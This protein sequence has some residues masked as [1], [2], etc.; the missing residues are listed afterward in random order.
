MSINRAN[1]KVGNLAQLTQFF[2]FLSIN[3]VSRVLATVLLSEPF[4][5]S[6]R[7]GDLLITVAACK[8]ESLL[9][10]ALPAQIKGRRCASSEVDRAI[11]ERFTSRRLLRATISRG[12]SCVHYQRLHPYARVIRYRIGAVERA[13]NLPELHVQIVSLGI[14]Q[15]DD[16]I[17]KKRSW[18][19]RFWAGLILSLAIIIFNEV[20]NN[21]T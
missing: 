8:G 17:L 16:E 14:T 5:R 9:A 7:A 18:R 11:R 1:K 2:L 4:L 15:G 3:Y 19:A 21:Q 20:T 10:V 6:S 12:S 13:R